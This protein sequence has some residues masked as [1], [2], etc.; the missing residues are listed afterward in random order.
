MKKL[1]ISLQDEA[2][3][4]LESARKHFP[5]GVTGEIVLMLGILEVQC[6]PE[7]AVELQAKLPEENF[8]VTEA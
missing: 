3:V 7:Q 6:T 4:T 5:T 1:I 2:R 8:I